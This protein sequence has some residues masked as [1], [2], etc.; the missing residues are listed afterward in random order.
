MPRDC[1]RTP[2]GEHLGGESVDIVADP[3]EPPVH[4]DL[5]AVSDAVGVGVVELH[6]TELS[7]GG[8]RRPEVE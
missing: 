6:H 3:E 2:W 5:A 4:E 1:W 8:P 7:C